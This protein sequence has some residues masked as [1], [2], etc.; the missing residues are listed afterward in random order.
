MH[1]FRLVFKVVFACENNDKLA[2]E[3]GMAGYSLTYIIQRPAYDLLKLFGELA[4]DGN[5]P[6]P[7]APGSKLIHKFLY[8][9]NTLEENDGHIMI[10]NGI[11]SS[12]PALFCR[13][14]SL[15]QEPVAGEAA[16]GQRDKGRGGAGYGTDGV[17]FF[18][19]FPCGQETGV[20]DAGGTGVTDERN[21]L[22]A[23]QPLHQHGNLAMLVVLVERDH[24]GLD[25]VMVQKAGGCARVFAGNR[26]CR[27]QDVNRT[28]RK[29]GQV[30]DGC[31][32]KVKRAQY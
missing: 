25:G 9:V 19:R 8:A 3:I 12:G 21:A 30:A 18:V 31:S 23:V 1:L 2:L 26:I 27:H 24:R 5:H 15:E 17:T 13:Q 29:I 7:V 6:L 28:L 10:G 4:A 32:D 20:G 16:G 14:E 11:Q 22:S